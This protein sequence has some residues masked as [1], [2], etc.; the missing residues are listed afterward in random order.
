[1]AI[2]SKKDIK[3]SRQ[4]STRSTSTKR[5]S[6]GYS[7][8]RL[9]IHVTVLQN[10]ETLSQISRRLKRAETI[11]ILSS[12]K[13][14][15]SLPFYP[16]PDGRLD[17]F[18]VK[19]GRSRLIVEPKWE[20][21]CTSNGEMISLSRQDRGRRE[22]ELAKGDY[23][24]V[25]RDDLRIMLRISDRP[26][27]KNITSQKYSTTLNPQ[28]RGSAI[29]HFISQKQEIYAFFAA[30]VVGLVVVGSIAFGLHAR[31]HGRP[32][33]INE[34]KDEYMISFV[35]PKH[36]E[37]A[38][39]LLQNRLDRTRFVQTVFKFYQAFS[40]LLI[41]SDVPNAD[42][43]LPSSINLYQQLSAATQSDL[44]AKHENQLQIDSQIA[45]ESSAGIINIPA[46]L[47]ESLYGK[48]LR[49]IDKINIMQEASSLNLITKREVTP[50]FNAD[51]PY[52]YENYRDVTKGSKRKPGD[53]PEAIKQIHVWAPTDS[54]QIMYQEAKDWANKARKNQQL[55]AADPAR[56]IHENDAAPLG[57]PHGSKY[58]TFLNDID[59]FLADEKFYNLRAVEWGRPANL[60]QTKSSP[61]EPIDTGFIETFIKKNRYQLQ[62][63]YEL[64]LRRDPVAKGV[65]EWYWKIDSRG[66][67]SNV[68]LIDSGI[69]DQSMIQCITRKILTWRFP[70][71]KRGGIEITYPFEFKPSKG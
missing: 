38:P 39:E 9:F 3:S 61:E 27:K 65:M 45:A 1:M 33:T 37:T 7:N 43:V 35:A 14:E 53:V 59:L 20:G 16:L 32:Q 13:N 34:I 54:E 64:A 42:L 5:S 66:V 48:M 67:V 2:F 55:I 63:C 8:S 4:L 26:F 58:T 40:N 17:I 6:G 24:S 18:E 46:V 10:G 62:L 19:K 23:A 15:L 52:D 47:G 25:S 31:P 50:A 11:S 30:L 70:R 21:L 51:E 22:Y 28:W 41:G 68:S 12:D 56:L 44:Q 57:L 49:I 60:S 29:A 36:L 71:T 69:R